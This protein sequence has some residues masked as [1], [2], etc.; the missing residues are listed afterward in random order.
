MREK[1]LRERKQAREDDIYA[2]L[3]ANIEQEVEKK[4]LAVRTKKEEAENEQ[5]RELFHFIHSQ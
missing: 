1:E 4:K 3:K 2:A 5:T